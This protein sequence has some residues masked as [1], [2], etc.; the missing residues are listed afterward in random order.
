MTDR[1]GTP[2][3]AERTA[4]RTVTGLE[5]KMCHWHQGLTATPVLIRILPSSSGP[6][7]AQYACGSCR[8]RHQLVPYA[9]R[10]R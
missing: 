1:T 6:G 5:P 7:I 8:R 2:A 4:V 3:A 9:E 10:R